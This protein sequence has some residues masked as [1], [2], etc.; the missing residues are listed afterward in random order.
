MQRF[1]F[2][3]NFQLHEQ[4]VLLVGLQ[5]ALESYQVKTDD[6]SVKLATV[7]RELIAELEAI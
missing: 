1:R 3:D 7:C 5:S 4:M 6:D 2:R